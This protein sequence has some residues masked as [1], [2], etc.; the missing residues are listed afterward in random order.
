MSQ[1]SFIYSFVAR[2][3]MLLAEYTEFT[4]NFPAIAAQCLQKLPSSNN[5][6]TYNCDHHTFNFLVEDGYA[7]CVVAKESVSK[8]ISIA[9]LERV[10]ADFKKRYGGGKADTA[11]AKSLNKEF[12]PVMKE[13][14]KYIINHAEEIVK[15]IKVKAQVSEVKSIMLENIDKALDR[16]E[17]LTILADKTEALRS[18]AQDFRK[19]GT[20]VRR[21]MWYQNMKIKLVVLG[22]LLVLVLVI[23]LSICG[24]F[25][26]TNWQ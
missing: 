21:K 26:C 23:W 2:G 3:T 24:G 20:Q 13:H 1:E 10:K 15:L 18:H 17:N 12:G 22:I 7:Y 16:G 8:Q 11:I 14:M 5:K 9:F 6:F 19:Q 4:G 25:D